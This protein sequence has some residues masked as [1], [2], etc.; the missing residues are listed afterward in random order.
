[1]ELGLRGR[2][3]IVAAASKGLGRA[4]AE[5]LAR[6]GAEVAICARSVSDLEK[7]ARHIKEV[8]GRETFWQALDVGN[9]KAVAEFVSNEAT[10]G[11][12]DVCVT[13]TG[14]PPSKLLAATTDE[15]WRNWTD[16]LLMSVVYFAKAV[17]PRMQK[18]T[19]SAF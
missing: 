7:A 10:F 2:V 17:L 13:N 12:V 19:G 11:R 4:V 15:D 14:G 6:E 16:Q 3:A 8:S 5:E 9:A 1:M 18:R